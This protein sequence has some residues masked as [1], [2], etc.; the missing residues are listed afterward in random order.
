MNART[1]DVSEGE[2]IVIERDGEQIRVRVHRTR[3]D[4]ARIT[5]NAPPGWRFVE[6][7]I[8]PGAPAPEPVG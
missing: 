1:R 5:V 7:A 6:P 4:Q 8:P 2:E 3:R